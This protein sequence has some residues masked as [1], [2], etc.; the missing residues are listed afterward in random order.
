M[1]T[2][3]QYTLRSCRFRCWRRIPA[4]GTQAAGTAVDVGQESRQAAAGSKA[5]CSDR[6]D[7]LSLN[8]VEF[9]FRR[10]PRSLEAM[11]FP[12]KCLT[13]RTFR[14]LLLVAFFGIA[15]PVSPAGEGDADAPR[16]PNVVIILVDDMGYGDPACYNP[17]SKIPTPNIDRLAREGMR[18]TDAHAAGPLCHISRYGLMTGRYPFR[19]KSGIWARQPVI[20]QGR[21]T[22]ASLAREQGYRTAMVGKWHLGFDESG[23]YEKPLPGG[24][25]DV[26]FES[27]FGIRASTD[28]PPY[29]YIR[30]DR[31]VAPPTEPIAASSSEGWSRIQGAFWREG[32]IAPDLELKDVL[33]RFTSEAVDVIRTYARNDDDS[34]LMLYLAYPAPHTPWLPA[35]EYEGTSG[36][37]MYGDFTVMVDAM[38]GKVL[39][40][41]DESQMSDQTLLLFSSDN[42]PTWYDRDV[43]R[44]GHDSSGGW[45]GMK[46]DAWE[47]GHRVPFIVRWP[48]TVMPGSTSD[49]LTC[50][51]DVLATLADL[52]GTTLPEDAGPDS[53][54]FLPVLRGE[55]DD[56]ARLRPSLVIPAGNGTLTIRSGDWK[57][58]T[59]LGSGGF[60]E[61]KRIKPGPDDPPGQLYHLA[62]DP[63]EMSNRY[64]QE[65]QIV[66]RLQAEL[67]RIESAGRHR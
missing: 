2:R 47:A 6:V 42:G 27:F 10:P 60:S 21:M 1:P 16:L 23:G 24:P 20:E 31:A 17:G 66:Q 64:L 57:L 41:L 62:E 22:I 13:V 3:G 14:Y 52:T 9:Q 65:P 50:F 49:H 34:P 48:G 35:P 37:G 45:R 30:G 25:V 4:D 26:G 8:P 5:I 55:Q 58:I 67:D 28:I 56:N 46:A 38:I 12:E 11:P 29:F 39:A 53:F 15:A 51:T 7:R 43:E 44:F 61:P 32:L 36:A 54:T 40:A 33:P 59:A 19:G 63:A 18:F